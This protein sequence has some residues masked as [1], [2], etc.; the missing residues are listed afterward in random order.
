MP[1]QFDSIE[2]EQQHFLLELQHRNA[3]VVRVLYPRTANNE[4]ELTVFR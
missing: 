1:L 3:K 2:A 4:K